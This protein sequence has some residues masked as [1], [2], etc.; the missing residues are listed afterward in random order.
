MQKGP[1]SFGPPGPLVYLASCQ[2][3]PWIITN[4]GRLARGPWQAT[5]QEQQAQPATF[6]F[7]FTL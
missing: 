4:A 6:A 1:G 7:T 5:V 3:Q 2:Y